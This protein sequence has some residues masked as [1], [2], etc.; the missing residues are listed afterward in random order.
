MDAERVRE[1]GRKA[2]EK[3]RERS[4]SRALSSSA[5]S[6]SRLGMRPESSGTRP[7]PPSVGSTKSTRVMPNSPLK[8]SLAGPSN[9]NMAASAS[10]SSSAPGLFL[11]PPRKRKRHREDGSE[12]SH[13]SSVVFVSSGAQPSFGQAGEAI[14]SSSR[15]APVTPRRPSGEQRDGY[16]KASPMTPGKKVKVEK[17][18]L[19]ASSSQAIPVDVSDDE[20]EGFEIVDPEVAKREI[21]AKASVSGRYPGFQSC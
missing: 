21:A 18:G 19:G 1:L 5:G 2:R 14:V 11:T 8:N 15:A 12:K 4:T 16:I 10:F 17:N 6:P 13:G 20:S 7:Q 9:S 3:G